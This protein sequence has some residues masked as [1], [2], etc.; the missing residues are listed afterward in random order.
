MSIQEQDEPSQDS[1]DGLDLGEDDAEIG[2]AMEQMSKYS[3]RITGNH[4]DEDEDEKEY[5]DEDED[6]DMIENNE[7]ENIDN[8]LSM[9]EKSNNCLLS[10]D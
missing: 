8:L 10:S 9:P 4:D 5:E 2:G 7:D 1:T 3:S 6:E